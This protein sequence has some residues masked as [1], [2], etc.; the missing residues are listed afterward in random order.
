MKITWSSHKMPKKAF[1]KIQYP[2]MIKKMKKLVVLGL[3]FNIKKAIKEILST[4]LV[5]G[6]TPKLYRETLSQKTKKK[7]KQ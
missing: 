3:Y 7:K 6:Q 1:D 5:P 4:E 2:F